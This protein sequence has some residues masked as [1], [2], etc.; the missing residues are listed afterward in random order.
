MT[1]MLVVPYE[2]LAESDRAKY[3][4]DVRVLE[5]AGWQME[6]GAWRRDAIN[7]PVPHNAREH[8]RGGDEGDFHCAVC[9][10]KWPCEPYVL[11]QCLVATTR[12]RDRAV[13]FLR[14]HEWGGVQ[15]GKPFCLHCDRFLNVGHTEACPMRA[16]MAD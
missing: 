16:L 5:R 15:D 10:E 3:G 6:G 13:E 7:E 1:G 14:R 4:I 9:F 12:E 11:R 8:R 2:W